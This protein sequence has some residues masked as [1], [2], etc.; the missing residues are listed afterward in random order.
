[1]ERTPHPINLASLPMGSGKMAKSEPA[2]WNFL[3]YQLVIIS[4]QAQGNLKTVKYYQGLKRIITSTSQARKLTLVENLLFSLLFALSLSL[5]ADFL[6]NYWY[7]VEILSSGQG[8]IE[9]FI[10]KM[11][12][13]GQNT[14]YWFVENREFNCKIKNRYAESRLG[15]VKSLQWWHRCLQSTKYFM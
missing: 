7:L 6:E 8:G 15:K 10:I 5:T 4:L 13:N 12:N 2:S 14:D 9:N 11:Q 3:I 1:M